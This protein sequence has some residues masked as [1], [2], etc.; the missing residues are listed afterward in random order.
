M[1]ESFFA[2]LK[3]NYSEKKGFRQQVFKTGHLCARKRGNPVDRGAAIAFL[4]E[5]AANKE[6]IPEWVSLENG[7]SGYEVHIKPNTVN[8]ASL[9]LIV[10][11]HNLALK[12]VKGFLV[13]YEEHDRPQ[14]P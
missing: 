11:K 12:E 6:L 9:K 1:S 7:N 3:N 4:K 2:L 5:I 10:K 13:V 8:T 14:G